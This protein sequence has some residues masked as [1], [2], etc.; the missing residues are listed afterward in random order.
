MRRVLMIAGILGI[1]ALPRA[2]GAEDQCT[3]SPEGIKTWSIMIDGKEYEAHPSTP[4][5]EGTTGLFH[6][7][8]AYTLP[9]RKFSVSLFR[10]NLDRDPKDED[11]SIHGLTLGYGATDRLELFGSYGLQNRVNADA[12]SQPGFVNDYPFVSTPWQ[13]GPGDLKV[14]M[15]YKLLDDYRG[16]AVGLALRGFVKLGTAD[17]TKGLGTGKTAVGLDLLLSK[18]LGHV[19]D[20]HGGIGYQFNS[21]PDNPSPVEIGDA[22]N[23]GIGLNIPACR[24]FQVQAEV[25]GAR[26][27]GAAFAQTNPV[28]LIVGPVVWIKGFFI[29][30]AVSRNL[31]FDDRGLNSRARSF[32]G[33]Q[34]SV[35]Y[36]PGT[37]CCAI[38]TPPPPRPPANRRPTVTCEPERPTVAPGETVGLRAVAS[39][40][41]RSSLTYVWTSSA[42]HVSGAGANVRLDTSGVAAPANVTATVRV[43]DGHGASAD[44]TCAVRIPAP[45]RRLVT[46]TCESTGFPPNLARLNNV[47]KACLDDVASRLRQDPRSHV[48]VVGHADGAERRPAL[49]ARQRAEAAKAY[50]VHDRG[51]EDAR[52]SLR[53]TDATGHGTGGAARAN[54]RVELIFVPDGAKPPAE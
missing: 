26:Y 6:L 20:I 19:A 47:D 33:W 15:K 38:T 36:H 52:V 7:P 51:M 42:G 2:T 25:T 13:T 53:A 16:E 18:S 5:Y 40:P 41:D 3:V 50:L 30:P 4:S 34:F 27:R 31:H 54:R 29:R 45:E 24:I 17:Q 46:I 12:L 22:L 32:T 49:L 23:W 9:K 14:G 39:D 11:I 44:A 21:H 37:A 8:S 48:I 28:D 35:G 1:L 43:S 10:N